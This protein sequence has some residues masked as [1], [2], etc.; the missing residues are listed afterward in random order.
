[1]GLHPCVLENL[2]LRVS[3]RQLSDT[4]NDYV[5]LDPQLLEN[6]PPLGRAR[7]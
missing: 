2:N 4:R 3:P 5:E 6:L 1:M 7:R